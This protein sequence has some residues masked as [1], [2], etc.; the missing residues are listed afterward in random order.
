METFELGNFLNR[1]LA[2]YKTYAEDRNIEFTP[3]TDFAFDIT[4]TADKTK[5][6]SLLRS[7]LKNTFDYSGA[8]S[9]I[10]SIRQLLQS[11]TTTLL[12]FSLETNGAIAAS[13]ERFSFFRSLVANRNLIAELGGKSE[14]ITAPGNGS[15]FKFVIG[16]AL[17]ETGNESCCSGVS[18][19]AGKK[20][21]VVDDND[22]NRT[23]LAHFLEAAGA[24]P[25]L[26]ANGMKAIELLEKNIPYDLI[27]LDIL[28]PQMDGFETAAYIRKKLKDD[29]PIIAIPARKKISIPLACNE[30]GI[31]NIITK[32]FAPAALLNLINKTL[33]PVAGEN[34]LLLKIA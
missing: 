21:L 16:L 1:C 8:T 13:T 7:A 28:M 12:E 9:V 3:V 31:D 34:E 33:H 18:F 26:A 29:R 22:I 14:F 17:A 2:D 30:V 10:F 25:L 23:T 27:L 32:P 19:L 6:R 4:V 15:V 11:Q 5:F 20:I 24:E